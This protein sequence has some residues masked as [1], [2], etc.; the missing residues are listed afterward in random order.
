LSIPIE[1]AGIGKRIGAWLIDTVLVILLAAV[2]LFVAS[3]YVDIVGY[4]QE[5]EPY[6]DKYEALYNTDFSISQEEYLKL[7]AQEQQNYDAAYEAMLTDPEATAVY[8]KVFMKY[9]AAVLLALAAAS[10]ILEFLVPVLQR[11][12]QSPGKVLFSVAV[13]R[14]NGIR[15]NPFQLFLRAIPGKFCFVILLPLSLLAT[16]FFGILGSVG[17]IGFL[18]LVIMH[19]LLLLLTPNHSALHDLLSGTVAVDQNYQRI[20]DN[21]A[22]LDEYLSSQ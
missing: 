7:S 17:L 16:G 8:A 5:L 1:H 11:R 15:A 13:I 4:V 3:A 10:F 18:V 21:Q 12:G 2:F 20:F 14:P 22:D 19:L 9:L 6:Y